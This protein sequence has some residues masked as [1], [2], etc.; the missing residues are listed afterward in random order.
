MPIEFDPGWEYWTP[1]AE[2]IDAF[3][4]DSVASLFGEYRE[5]AAGFRFGHGN[6]NRGMLFWPRWTPIKSPPTHRRCLECGG[7]F[8]IQRRDH[9]YCSRRCLYESRVSPLRPTCPCGRRCRRGRTYCSRG[10]LRASRPPRDIPDCLVCNAPCPRRGRLYCSRTC[11]RSTF[12]PVVSRDRPSPP[13]V[14]LRECPRCKAEFHPWRAASVYCSRACRDAAIRAR[15]VV[16]CD[17][18]LTPFTQ[19]EV[20]QRYCSVDCRQA[21]RRL[22]PDEAVCVHCSRPFPPT[23]PGQVYCSRRCGGDAAAAARRIPPPPQLDTM[24]AAGLSIAAAA[25]MMG[26][27]VSTMKRWRSS[28]EGVRG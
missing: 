19:Q 10:C 18:C 24:F 13:P 1:S 9:R 11:W 20:G 27:S 22:R 28:Q 16:A 12:P 23:R 6:P 15:A 4:A 26:V 21:A 5:A 7:W 17:R 2:T 3:D 25:T 8:A 14:I